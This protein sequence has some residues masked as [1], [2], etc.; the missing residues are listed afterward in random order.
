MA[1]CQSLSISS[2]HAAGIMAISSPPATERFLEGHS[3][4]NGCRKYTVKGDVRY[5]P[6][7]INGAS[8]ILH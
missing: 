8:S 4:E 2:R 7:I 6:V 1:S 5:P 3:G